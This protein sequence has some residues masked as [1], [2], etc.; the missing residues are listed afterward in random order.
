MDGLAE[1]RQLSAYQYCGLIMFVKRL[2]FSIL[3][4]NPF[5][6]L[7]SFVFSVDH[8]WSMGGC[9]GTDQKI[10]FIGFVSRDDHMI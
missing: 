6:L 5:S 3:V 10:R 7:L 9:I 8:P 1:E 2:Q 4:P